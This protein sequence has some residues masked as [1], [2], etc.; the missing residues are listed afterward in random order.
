MLD[1][2]LMLSTKQ[3]ISTYYS[4]CGAALLQRQQRMESAVKG[5]LEGLQNVP[6]LLKTRISWDKDPILHEWIP[7]MPLWT[8][9][10]HH[11]SALCIHGRTR[12]QR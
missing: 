1:V 5:L 6:L 10:G 8:S 2:P 9:N 11:I 3:G 4:S 12:A 7:K